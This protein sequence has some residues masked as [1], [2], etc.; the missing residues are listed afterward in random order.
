M[1]LSIID[2]LIDY[3]CN[4]TKDK[5]SYENV[6][7]EVIKIK[8]ESEELRKKSLEAIDQD[9]KILKEILDGYKKRKEEPE[10]LEEICKKSAEFCLS[11]TENAV[12]TLKLAKRISEIGNR[13]LSSDFKI[14]KMYAFTSVEAGIENVKILEFIFTAY[15]RSMC[16]LSCD[17]RS[18]YIAVC[19]Q[20]LQ[21]VR[22]NRCYENHSGLL[23]HIVLYV[24]VSAY[25]TPASVKRGGYGNA[26][27]P[28]QMDSGI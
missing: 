21:K 17:S 2:A 6:R 27:S 22:R 3:I 14:C 12:K 10:K 9:E 28:D 25:G 19:Y 15:S 13:M 23:I 16:V 4:L 26:G 1:V 11:V 18:F 20:A 7:D 8:L 24:C 5:K